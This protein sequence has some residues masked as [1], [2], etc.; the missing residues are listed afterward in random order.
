E[1][2]FRKVLYP[3]LNFIKTEKSKS[4]ILMVCAFI[5]YANLM[6]LT[7]KFSFLPS[8]LFT[9]FIFFITTILNTNIYEKT[10]AFSFVLLCSF[11]ILQLFFSAVLSNVVGVGAVSGW[12]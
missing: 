7:Q 4:K 2:L 3:Q 11:N 12:F 5:V 1:I 6:L 8:V 9:Y 10:K